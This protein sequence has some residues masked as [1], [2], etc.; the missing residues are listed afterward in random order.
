MGPF[1][2]AEIPPESVQSKPDSQPRPKVKP[3]KIVNVFTGNSIPVDGDEGRLG[4]RKGE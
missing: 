4:Q 3:R 2:F 1:L